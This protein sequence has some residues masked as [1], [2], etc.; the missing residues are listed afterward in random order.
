MNPMTAI[1]IQA[2]RVADLP[3][4]ALVADPDQPRKQFGDASLKELAESLK[5]F[6]VLNPLVVR[7]AEKAGKF[8]VVDGERRMRA[9]KTAGLKKVPVLLE[10]GGTDIAQRRIAQV[11]VNNL[12]ESLKPMDLAQTLHDLQHREKLTANDIAAW[13]AKSG[14]RLTSEEI[15]R[16]MRLVDLPKWAADM[17]DA[18]QLQAADA[19]PLLEVLKDPAVL[20]EVGK[21]LARTVNWR[22]KLMPQEVRNAIETSYASIGVNL[23]ATSE[24]SGASTVYFDYRKVCTKCDAYRKVGTNAT[25]CM[26]RKRFTERNS[27]AKAA[28][29]QPGGKPPKKASSGA[30]AEK[31]EAERVEAKAAQRERSASEKLGEY[32]DAWL[33]EQICAVIQTPTGS[34]RDGETL[35][36]RLV[37]YYAAAM[38]ESH[39]DALALEDDD[40]RGPVY[41]SRFDY[42]N[43]IALNHSRIAMW[44]AIGWASIDDCLAAPTGGAQF[45]AIAL[46]CVAMLSPEQVL[47]VVRW[48]NLDVEASYRIDDGYLGLKTKADLISLAMRAGIEG[49]PARVGEAKAFLLQPENVQV[50]GFPHDLRAIWEAP[51]AVAEPDDDPNTYDDDMDPED[52]DE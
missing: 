9:A 33:R 16:T 52:I 31:A 48:L 26:D 19:M 7:A 45:N 36:E 23:T 29:L 41:T 20:K 39:G 8:I 32:F 15:G 38:L 17:I 13:G 46:A 3:L 12:R 30:T 28:G 43:R 4:S 34:P 22:G 10:Q 35:S 21:D 24:W 1:R 14:L 5:S 27:E 40:D 2:G 25:F 42:G 51:P 11:V 47:T 49:L 44:K 6:G 37:H 50:I 18:E